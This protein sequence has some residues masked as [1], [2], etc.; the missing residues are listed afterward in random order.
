[1]T[2]RNAIAAAI[3]A[4]AATAAM[5]APADAALERCSNL[6]FDGS[7]GASLCAKVTGIDPGSSLRV[8]KAPRLDAPIV[9]RLRNGTVV[10]A[11]CWTKGPAVRGDTYWIGLY[12]AGGATYVP[13]YYL[14]T[15]R[16]SSVPGRLTHCP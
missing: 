9:D 1:M 4:V 5:S 2:R 11:D 13:D 16:P 12:G 15:G 10:E 7:D 6:G 14:T 8:R 3:A